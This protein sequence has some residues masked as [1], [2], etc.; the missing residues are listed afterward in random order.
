[1]SSKDISVCFLI[2]NAAILRGSLIIR[3]LPELHMSSGFTQNEWHTAIKILS[4]WIIQPPIQRVT[5]SS[6]TCG[7]YRCP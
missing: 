5:F 3:C 6:L 7:A 4:G 1:M 2:R